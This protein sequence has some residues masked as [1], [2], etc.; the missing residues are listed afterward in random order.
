MRRAHFGD[1]NPQ[2]RMLPYEHAGSAGVIEVDVA[3]EQVV[4]LLEGQAPLLETLY[5]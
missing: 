5:E 1:V 3:Q 2:G 4:D